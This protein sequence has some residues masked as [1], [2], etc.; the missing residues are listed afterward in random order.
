[1]R[2]LLVEDEPDMA[3]LVRALVAGAG[4]VVDQAGGLGEALEASR[5]YNYD[6]LLLD[7]R[8]PDGDGLSLLPVV[9]AMSPGVRVMILTAL[10]ELSERVMGLDAGADDYLTK[11]FQGEE[12]IARIRACLRR[13]GGAP[14]PPLVVGL[15]ALDLATREVSVAGRPVALNRRELMLLQ[16]MMRRAS[17]VTTREA[18]LEEVYS[19]LDE[20]QANTLDT[21]VSRLRRRLADLDSGVAIHT[22]RGI[23]YILTEQA[24]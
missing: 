15:L 4:F 9:R 7:R 23:G 14:L 3:R 2:I 1:M 13:P 17:R 18:L 8:L 20:V 22:V 10:D 16:A 5:Q 6:L 12:L 19:L 11:P 24:S 21:L